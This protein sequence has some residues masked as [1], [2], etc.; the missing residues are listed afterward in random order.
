MEEYPIFEFIPF[1][2][3]I[4]QTQT[5]YYAALSKSDKKGHSTPFIEYMLEV[6][7][8]SLNNLLDKTGNQMNTEDRLKYFCEVTTNEFT[9][10]DYMMVFKELSTA[11]ASRDLKTGVDL[12]YFQKTGDKKN[13]VYSIIAKK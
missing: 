7:N 6:I 10:K 11:T 2:N 5:D 1:E 3:M 9:R 12:N 4:H 13:T 8:R